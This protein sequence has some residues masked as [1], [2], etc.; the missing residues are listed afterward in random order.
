MS[1]TA[2]AAVCH[3]AV[4]IQARWRRVLARRSFQ[5]MREQKRKHIWAATVIQVCVHVHVVV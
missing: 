1:R 3:A 5:L 2:V 4:R